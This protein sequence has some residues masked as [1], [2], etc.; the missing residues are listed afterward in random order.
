[1]R[2]LG[3]RDRYGRNRVSDGRALA[4]LKGAARPVWMCRYDQ[5]RLGAKLAT[6]LGWL[7][8]VLMDDLPREL[9]WWWITCF[10]VAGVMS[11]IRTVPWRV[12][13]LGVPLA[14]TLALP[15]ALGY[16]GPVAKFLVVMI[17]LSVFGLLIDGYRRSRR[18]GRPSRPLL[19]VLFVPVDY[20]TPVEEVFE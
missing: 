15:L 20:K 2:R 17:P 8:I 16:R 4:Y 9:P 3:W 6:C 11:L 19:E 5:V 10:L 7:W 14:L 12:V 13:A 1:M 18:A